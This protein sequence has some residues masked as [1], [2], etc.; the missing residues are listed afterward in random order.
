MTIRPIDPSQRTAARA[1]GLAYLCALVP[2]IFAEFY[3]R[4]H[5][6]GF[7]DLAAAAGNIAAHSRLFRLGIAANLLVSAIDLVLI[8]GLYLALEKVNR[9]LAVLGAFFRLIETSVLVAVTFSDFQV[10][11]VLSHAAYM[12]PL[13]ADDVQAMTGLAIAAHHDI[14]NVGLAMFGIG[15][16]IFCVLWLRSGYIPKALAAGGVLASLLVGL[17]AFVFVVFPGAA[18]V[19]TIVIS[20]LPIFLFELSM[21]LWLLVKGLPPDEAAAVRAT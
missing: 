9:G 15:S 17:P 10:L 18:T 1:V 19:L 6:I 11:R 5:L 8:A 14:Y 12:R 4:S 13:E 21:G 3:V 2:A 20:G 7:G 16:T